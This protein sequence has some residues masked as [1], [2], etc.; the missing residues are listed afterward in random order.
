MRL[1]TTSLFATAVA[2][3]SQDTVDD[4]ASEF[5]FEELDTKKALEQRKALEAPPASDRKSK[6]A[7]IQE[8]IDKELKDAGVETKESELSVA[9]T[10]KTTKPTHMEPTVGATTEEE[11]KKNLGKEGKT[12]DEKE[13]DDSG[14]STT[15]VFAALLLSVA[16]L[17]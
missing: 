11:K 5:L 2:K 6:K 8:K 1:L 12:G 3:P 15:S 4:R 7:N 16:L 9:K 10:N 13:S 17:L 14:A